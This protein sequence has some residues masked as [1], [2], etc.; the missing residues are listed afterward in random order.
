MPIRDLENITSITFANYETTLNMSVNKDVVMGNK[1]FD[2]LFQDISNNYDEIRGLS[3]V[4]SV[5][6]LRTPFISSNKCEESYA[7]RLE[8]QNDIIVEE[9]YVI[10]SNCVLTLST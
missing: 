1:V 8:K 6:S 10:V 9:D 5:H 7:K 3:P 2:Y 4:Y